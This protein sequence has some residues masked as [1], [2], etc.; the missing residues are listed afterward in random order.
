MLLLGRL[1]DS[2]PS[3]VWLVHPNYYDLLQYLVNG[4]A[5]AS[6]IIKSSIVYILALLCSK[7]GGFSHDLLKRIYPVVCS[8]LASAKLH[9]LIVN[10]LILL[11]NIVKVAPYI[12][13]SHDRP[14]DIDFFWTNSFKRFL[15][16]CNETVQLSGLQ[17]ISTVFADN[18]S[19][20][21][22]SLVGHVS[23]IQ[24]S[25]LCVMKHLHIIE[26]LFEIL[27]TVSNLLL[28]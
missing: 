27:P 3:S 20:I 28:Q 15:L 11:T 19:E 18:S 1:I 12:I 17:C 8:L 5:C 7:F 6:E 16:S 22:S 23:G 13:C 25:I 14:N 21:H 10:S 26:C 9:E 24:A 4:L 2:N